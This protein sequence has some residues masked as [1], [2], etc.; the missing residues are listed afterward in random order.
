MHTDVCGKMDK[1][2]L[3]GKEY[4]VSFIDDKSRYVWTYPIRKKSEAFEKFLGWKAKAER[5]SERKLKKLRSDN[6]G[7]YISNEFEQYLEQEGIHHQNTIPKTPQQNGVAERMNRTLEESI[8]SMLC[9]SKLPKQFWAEAL[10]TAT[11]LRNRSPTKA[12]KDMTPF[13]AWSSIKPDVQHLRVFGSI[14]YSHIHKSERQKL[15]PKSRKAILLGYG[16]NVKGYRL[17]DPQEKRVYYSRDV[18]FEE[19]KFKE[20]KRSLESIIEETEEETN[21]LRGEEVIIPEMIN[22]ESDTEDMND[23]V[24][25]NEEENNT[26]RRSTRNRKEPEYYGEWVNIASISEE[27]KTVHEALSG[28]KSNEWTKAMQSEM[29][30]LNENQVWELVEL[31]KGRKAIGCKW[32]FKTKID[33]DGNIERYKARLVAQGY[34]QKFGV[35]YDQTFSPVVSFESIRSI[36]AIAAKNG[37]KLHQMDVKTAFLNGELSEEIFLKQP[38]GFIVKGFENHVCKL[39]RSIYGLK[40]SARCWNVELDRKLKDMGFK[41]CKS[42][43]CIYIKDAK[44]GYCIIA[45]YVD[46]LIV[47]GDNEKNIDYT[48]KTISAKFEVTDMGLLHYFLGVKVVQKSDTGDIWIG[49]PNF[50]RDLLKKFQM[51]ECKQVETPSDPSMKLCKKTESEEEVDKVK[52]QSAVGSLLYLSTRSRPDIAFAV[53]NAAR[54]CSQPSQ[55]HWSAVKRV[56]RYLKG[57]TD[58]GLL[59]Q[60]ANVNLVGYSDADWAGDTNDRKSTSGYVFMMSGSAISWRSKKQTSVALST[61]EAEYIA[62]SSATQEAMWLRQ[63]FSSLMKD[64]ELSIPTTIYEDNQSTICMARNNQSHGRSKHVD[65]KYHFVREQVEQQTIETIYC[66][67]EEMT[68]DILT[69]SLLN[70]QFKRLRTKLGM[71]AIIQEEY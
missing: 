62:L 48:K 9:E 16:E 15:D 52:Y 13:E 64:Y 65:I 22:T 70:H 19:M 6:G 23:D 34:S 10:S 21:D 24:N 60:H 8:R 53:G 55:T 37:L 42:D 68:A 61:A 1:P 69:K 25:D 67:S 54:Y 30:S 63:L 33:G 29:K 58:L 26:V 5:E 59:Y 12:V 35:D 40:Q 43:P 14:C 32:I 49:Q 27:P 66:R 17:Y 57:T 71:T 45:V 11:Y 44:E 2:S 39:K 51:A 3:S 41:Q 31:P 50:T 56:L 47:G 46:D 4:F 38:E 20:S 7:E 36:A 28:P 18:L